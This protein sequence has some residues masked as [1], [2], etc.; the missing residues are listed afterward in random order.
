M[1][2]L[3]KAFTRFNAFLVRAT[4]GRVGGQLGAQSVLLLETVGRK[5]GKARTTPISYYRDGEQYL[6]VASNWGEDGQPAWYLNLLANPKVQ[7]LVKGKAI[8]V[9]GRPA[10]A[11]ERPRL[12]QLVT[13]QNSQF[14]AYQNSTKREIPVVILNP[15]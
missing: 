6:V 10:T 3:T 11:E 4:G 1:N 9:T 14:T 8:A 12:W 13:S 15:N 5:T 2:A 7:I